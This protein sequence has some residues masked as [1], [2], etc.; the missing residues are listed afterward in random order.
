MTRTGVSTPQIFGISPVLLSK[1]CSQHE[2]FDS[3]L[4]AGLCVLGVRSHHQGCGHVGAACVAADSRSSRCTGAVHQFVTVSVWQA[5][6]FPRSVP[7]AG[8]QQRPCQTSAIPAASLG[9][10]ISHHVHPK[11]AALTASRALGLRHRCAM[12]SPVASRDHVVPSTLCAVLQSSVGLKWSSPGL[13]ERVFNECAGQS[14]VRRLPRLILITYTR[15][16]VTVLPICGSHA[17]KCQPNSY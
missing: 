15:H 8:A 11:V 1:S 14:H 16:A 7:I 6:K 3:L 4:T 12:S 17:A 9:E 13:P 5:K 2:C 10:Y